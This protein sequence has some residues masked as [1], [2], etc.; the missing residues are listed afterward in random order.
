MGGN[1]DVEG[2]MRGA[3]GVE[4]PFGRE[5]A[6]GRSSLD[7]REWGSRSEV[8]RGTL[9]LVGGVQRCHVLRA[10]RSEVQGRALGGREAA[11][12]V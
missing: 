6:L 11:R 5:R 7:D 10:V 9:P 2:P 1:G 4:I 8:Y 3:A 12:K